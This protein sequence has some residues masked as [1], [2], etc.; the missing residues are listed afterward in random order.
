MLGW[1]VF[2]DRMKV[3]RDESV[4]VRR[5]TYDPLSVGSRCSAESGAGRE[6]PRASKKAR[7]LILSKFTTPTHKFGYCP[8]RLLKAFGQGN[9]VLVPR[10]IVVSI[11]SLQSFQ[12]IIS[13]ALILFIPSESNIKLTPGFYD[14]ASI[15]FLVSESVML[16]MSSLHWHPARPIA[17]VS[18]LERRMDPYQVR[19]G[20]YRL[21]R[22]HGNEVRGWVRDARVGDIKCICVGIENANCFGLIKEGRALDVLHVTHLKMRKSRSSSHNQQQP[23]AGYFNVE[24]DF[25]VNWNA[26]ENWKREGF[27]GTVWDFLQN[28][29]N[30]IEAIKENGFIYYLAT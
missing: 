14:A 21:S 22:A 20:Y 13:F 3:L 25:K 23:D 9:R 12:D 1:W 30:V 19:I 17:G 15:L 11:A 6:A 26:L 5:T 10:V 27:T 8:W 24:K 16:P 29:A 7:Q 4:K 18:H 2:Q 28:I